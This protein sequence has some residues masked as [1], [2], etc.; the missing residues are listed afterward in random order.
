MELRNGVA[1]IAIGKSLGNPVPHS[2]ELGNKMVEFKK[3]K[4]V[5]IGERISISGPIKRIEY[6]DNGISIQFEM[7]GWYFYPDENQIVPVFKR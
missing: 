7:D 1:L 4:D 2:L 3:V 6:Q 5:N